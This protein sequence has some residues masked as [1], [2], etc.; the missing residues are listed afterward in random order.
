MGLLQSLKA[1]GHSLT[2][3]IDYFPSFNKSALGTQAGFIDGEGNLPRATQALTADAIATSIGAVMGTSCVTTYVE[4]AAG[5]TEGGRTGFTAIVVALLFLLA[6]LFIPI[7]EAVPGFATTPA[8][9][10]VGVMMMAAV[11]HIQWSD[12]AEAIPAF[13][14]IF[15]IPFSFS[16]AAGL[17]AGLVAYPVIKV[18]QG[19][20]K[21]VTLSTWIL[22]ALFFA[23]FVFMTSRFG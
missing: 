7:F 18:F 19:K 17:S 9:L 8:L 11:Q 16:I 6:L 20:A 13:L 23:R 2:I 14:T 1:S 3:F 12:L 10:I 4:S 5:V 21:E 15:L 22:A